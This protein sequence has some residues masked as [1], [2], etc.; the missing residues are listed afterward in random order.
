PGGNGVSVFDAKV[1]MRIEG[2]SKM[3]FGPSAVLGARIESSK[4]RRIPPVRPTRIIRSGGESRLSGKT[5]GRLALKPKS[6]C[7]K[8]F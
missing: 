6:Y 4:Y 8:N 5:P 3:S 1:P 7:S 2:T